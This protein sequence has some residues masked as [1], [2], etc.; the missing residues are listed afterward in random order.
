MHVSCKLKVSAIRNSKHLK[1]TPHLSANLWALRPI[2][3]S[4]PYNTMLHMASDGASCSSWSQHAI[5]WA[6]LGCMHLSVCPH[7][8]LSSFVSLWGLF[9]SSKYVRLYD[10]LS[11]CQSVFITILL[12]CLI[13]WL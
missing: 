4:E 10:C 1:T 13:C 12:F 11:V 7:G 6:L 2:V 3:P 8:R 9:C 5:V